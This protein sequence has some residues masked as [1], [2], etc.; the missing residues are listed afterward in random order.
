MNSLASSI[1]FD[2]HV[3]I[4]TQTALQLTGED[5]VVPLKWISV[6][7]DPEDASDT[8]LAIHRQSGQPALIVEDVAP[9][10]FLFVEEV[11]QDEDGSDLVQS[12]LSVGDEDASEI[13]VS[14]ILQAEPEEVEDTA[15]IE[16][17]HGAIKLEQVPPVG[18]I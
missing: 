15:S 10:E 4:A 8:D 7:T 9:G 17:S 3:R 5:S 6:A 16:F 1:R 18:L 14:D 12:D 2:A 11:S 13:M